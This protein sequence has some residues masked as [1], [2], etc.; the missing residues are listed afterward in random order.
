[1]TAPDICSVKIV[2][3]PVRRAARRGSGSR[4]ETAALA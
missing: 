1:V 3:H 2:A 4:S